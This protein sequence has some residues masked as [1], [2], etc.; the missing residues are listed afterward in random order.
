MGI[1]PM[2][3]RRL[4]LWCHTTLLDLEWVGPERRRPSKRR[5]EPKRNGVQSLHHRNGR[6]SLLDHSHGWPGDSL[7]G[8]LRLWLGPLVVRFPLDAD[9][10]RLRVLVEG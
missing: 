6:Q 9:R 5:P 2:G 7:H 3:R 1:W 10:C 4:G 8:W